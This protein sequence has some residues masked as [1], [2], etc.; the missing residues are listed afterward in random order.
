MQ[1]AVTKSSDSEAVLSGVCFSTH[2]FKKFPSGVEKMYTNEFYPNGP[3]TARRESFAISSVHVHFSD[4][5]EFSPDSERYFAR[6][7]VLAKLVTF[8]KLKDESVLRWR[9]LQ[10]DGTAERQ[11]RPP[12]LLR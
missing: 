6:R 10:T 11:C 7:D 4:K 9:S 12:G 8:A 2:R 1:T 3:R 5:N